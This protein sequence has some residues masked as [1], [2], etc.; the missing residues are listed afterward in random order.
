M[1]RLPFGF[2]GPT[3]EGERCFYLG[4]LSCSH[5]SEHG[6]PSRIIQEHKHTLAYPMAE[7]PAGGIFD[8]PDGA[9]L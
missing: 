6:T 8:G 5:A 1:A 3:G 2:G 9:L 7:G 4:Q